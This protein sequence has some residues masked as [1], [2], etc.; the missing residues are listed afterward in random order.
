LIVVD[1]LM[2]IR[3]QTNHGEIGRALWMGFGEL[4]DAA[5]DLSG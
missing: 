1:A 5:S 4:S 3:T 2:V